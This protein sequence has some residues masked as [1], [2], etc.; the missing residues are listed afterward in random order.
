VKTKK[1]TLFSVIGASALVALGAVGGAVVTAS[2][3]T[4]D[5]ASSTMSTGITV[6]ATPAPTAPAVP[7]AVPQIKGPAPLPVEEQGLP[8]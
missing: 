6:T 1:T 8:G 2:A 7:Q 3:G 4:S 5:V